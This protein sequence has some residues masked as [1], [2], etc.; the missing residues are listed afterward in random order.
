MNTEDYVSLECAKLLK[1]KGYN[2]PV[3]SQYTKRG[4][5]WICQE[6]ENFNESTGCFSRPTLY[7][8]Q[9]WLREIHNI[10]VLPV[11]R[12]ESTIKDYCCNVYKN[13]KV[14]RCKV[15][16]GEDFYECMNEGLVEALNLI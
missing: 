4:S 2:E 9:K 13:A 1:E 10:D 6:P 16:Y 15:A 14:V 3:F 12:E 11:I 5:V 8:A 7:E